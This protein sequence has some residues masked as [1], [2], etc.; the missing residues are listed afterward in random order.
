MA[1]CVRCTSIQVRRNGQI[2]EPY[3]L[4]SRAAVLRERRRQKQWLRSTR[5]VY[6][7]PH[8]VIYF[9]ATAAEKQAFLRLALNF[10]AGENLWLCLPTADGNIGQEIL[11]QSLEAV[12]P[13]TVSREQR[14]YLQRQTKLQR[15]QRKYLRRS[16]RRCRVWVHSS[17]QQKTMGSNFIHTCDEL[18]A[19]ANGELS[20]CCNRLTRM[21]IDESVMSWLA[22]DS[23]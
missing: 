11:I 9:Q 2:R 12:L 23:R 4:Q 10:A 1:D 8:L 17:T 20:L 6:E 7:T 21:M 14:K 3:K 13:V 16:I 19:I 22:T 5:S 15:L 18:D